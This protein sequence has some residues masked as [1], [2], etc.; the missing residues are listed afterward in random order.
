MTM[1]RTTVLVGAFVGAAAIV[2]LAL[3]DLGSHQRQ[4]GVDELFDL[5]DTIISPP[6]RRNLRRRLC[7]SNMVLGCLGSTSTLETPAERAPARAK[8]E[9]K[10][11][12][13]RL[14]MNAR[15]FKRKAGGQDYTYE[16]AMEEYNQVGGSQDQF[17]N[18]DYTK[19]SVSSSGVASPTGHPS[20]LYLFNK[21]TRMLRR[22]MNEPTKLGKYRFVYSR[23]NGLPRDVFLEHNGKSLR[24]SA[25]KLNVLDGD[26][27]PTK[28]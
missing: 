5:S 16:Y 6:M 7:L 19:V 22:A 25:R 15:R 20:T 26:T 1:L 3:Q 12:L 4:Q 18:S 17:D 13:L 27:S 8:L 10:R 9:M 28:Y 23:R 11:A 2:V 14:K 21:M 24:I